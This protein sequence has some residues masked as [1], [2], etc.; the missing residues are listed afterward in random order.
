MKVTVIGGGIAGVSTALY[1]AELGAEVTCLEANEEVGLE[2]SYMNGGLGCASLTQPWC[3]PGNL[4]SFFQELLFPP[5]SPSISVLWG[6]VW[7]DVEFWRWSA[8]FVLSSLWPGRFEQ[9]FEASFA[10]SRF[11]LH[12][13]E[14]LAEQ[15]SAEGGGFRDFRGLARGTVQ[16]YASSA[17]QQAQFHKLSLV[18]PGLALQSPAQVAA[19]GP[20]LQQTLSPVWGV[21][22]SLDRSFDV[23]LL[24]LELK[25]RAGAAG[26]VFEPN[27]RVEGI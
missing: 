27:T 21:S 3:S 22:S 7:R 1:L 4:R 13:M 15:G 17:E 24:C 16:L 14:Q 10:L 20:V 26:V 25:R 2:T 18:V 12:C 9:L 6:Q 11:S 23:H 8:H 19:L 5:S